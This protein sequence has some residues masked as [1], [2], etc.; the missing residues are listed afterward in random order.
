MAQ[1]PTVSDLLAWTK[2]DSDVTDGDGSPEDTC[3]QTARSG[4]ERRC[5][6][7]LPDGSL[8]P[9]ATNYPDE[10][11]QAV[12][13]VAALGLEWRDTPGGVAGFGDLGVARLLG[14]SGHIQEL[15][16][17]FLNMDGFA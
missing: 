9:G 7:H 11:R 13:E 17:D 12:L 6:R 15:I 5:S 8:L 10:L 14:T 16:G 2:R 4:I 1:R 3:L